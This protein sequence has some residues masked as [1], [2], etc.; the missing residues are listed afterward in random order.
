MDGNKTVTANFSLA[1]GKAASFKVTVTGIEMFNGSTWVSLFSGAAQLDI[2]TGGIFPGVTG[3][4]L[5]QGTYTKIRVTFKNS[6]PATGTL[7]YGGTA[8]YTTAATFGG[9]TNLASTPT[10]VSGS[11]AA[12]TFRMA[13]WG[14]LNANVV[15]EF[16][17]TPITVSDKTDYQPTLR[18]TISNRFR[19]MGVS[20]SPGTY[21]FEHAGPNVSIVE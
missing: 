11:M 10:T 3:L 7:S 5:G 16:D 9:Q 21:Y 18:F 19:L 2:V 1:T 12:Y 14:A 4:A 6:F 17:I 13:G 20:G 8:Y 15:R